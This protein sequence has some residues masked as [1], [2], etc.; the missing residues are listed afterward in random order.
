MAVAWVAG[1]TDLVATLTSG[2]LRYLLADLAEAYV[3]YLV[4]S[5]LD[6]CG[7]QA[8]FFSLAV[9]QSDQRA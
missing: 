6:N 1:R 7:D 5:V 8:V 2:K 4:R 9:F 3:R